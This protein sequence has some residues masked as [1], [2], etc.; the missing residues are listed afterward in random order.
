MRASFLQV[1]SRLFSLTRSAGTKF[2]SW[3]TFCYRDI[4]NQCPEESNSLD[5]PDGSNHGSF[6]MAGGTEWL[7]IAFLAL[8]LFGKGP[9]SPTGATVRLIRF[10]S[11]R[12]FN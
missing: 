6:G 5:R 2:D 7:L 3:R 9:G 1:M 8:L 10:D 12:I 4:L 11:W